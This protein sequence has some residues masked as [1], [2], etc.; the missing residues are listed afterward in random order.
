MTL[1]TLSTPQNEK[2]RF[3]LENVVAIIMYETRVGFVFNQTVNMAPSIANYTGRNHI[4]FDTSLEGRHSVHAS[5]AS[6]AFEQAARAAGLVKIKASG[7]APAEIYLNEQLAVSI[8]FL[9]EQKM[10]EIGYI[11]TADGQNE[12]NPVFQTVKVKTAIEDMGMFTRAVNDYL[13]NTDAVNWVKEVNLYLK[14]T[15]VDEWRS[16][17]ITVA[18]GKSQVQHLIQIW[19]YG[20]CVQWSMLSDL[21]S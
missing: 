15:D 17:P 19:H 7:C 14:T 20:K 3:Q 8:Q 21:P 18:E 10:V 1:F 11:G 13:E 6:S 5:I 12:E 2:Y 16:K 9:Q 4:T